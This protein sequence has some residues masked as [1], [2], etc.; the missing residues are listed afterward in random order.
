MARKPKKPAVNQE[1]K[2][3]NAPD[4]TP[5][6]AASGDSNGDLTGENVIRVDLNDQMEVRTVMEDELAGV[7]GSPSPLSLA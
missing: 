2:A 7:S 6:S 1:R 5:K 3:H 4:N